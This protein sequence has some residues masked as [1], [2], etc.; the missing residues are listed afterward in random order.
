MKIRQTVETLALKKEKLFV[1]Y[2]QD[3]GFIVILLTMFTWVTQSYLQYKF[4][5]KWL[6]KFCRI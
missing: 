3:S 2:L 1:L 6:L 4:V 5:Q